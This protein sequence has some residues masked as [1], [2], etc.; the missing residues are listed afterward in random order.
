MNVDCLPTDRLTTI[1]LTTG[2]VALGFGLGVIWTAV[3]T[4]QAA[5]SP[6]PG[7]A[8]SLTGTYNTLTLGAG[9]LFLVGSCGALALEIH[10][11]THE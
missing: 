6:A 11:E 8:A 10:G 5:P 2:M 4:M 7:W 3:V 1:L 9:G